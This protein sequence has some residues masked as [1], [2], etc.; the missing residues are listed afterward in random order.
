MPEDTAKMSE[1]AHLR[2]KYQAAG[3]SNNNTNPSTTLASPGNNLTV[4]EVTSHVAGDID[5]KDIVI[6]YFDDTS[7]LKD[8]PTYDHVALGG[9]FDHLHNGHRKLLYLAVCVARREL[10]VGVTADSMLS[11]KA[12]ANLIDAFSVRRNRVEEYVRKLNPN[13]TY[14]VVVSFFFFIIIR[15][16]HAN[17]FF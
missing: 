12:S 4:V 13:L 14:N 10:T 2:E 17:V 3:T 8:L 6:S 7:G 16:K 9:S 1:V 11:S 5:N 15:R